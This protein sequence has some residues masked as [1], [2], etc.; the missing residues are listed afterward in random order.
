MQQLPVLRRKLVL[1][2]HL[3]NTMTHT[4]AHVYTTGW[5]FHLSKTG[6]PNY[7]NNGLI[8]MRVHLCLKLIVHL[9]FFLRKKISERRKIDGFTNDW[10]CARMWMRQKHTVKTDDIWTFLP[11]WNK[12][13]CR[14][15][16][17]LDVKLKFRNCNQTEQKVCEPLRRELSLQVWVASER[18][19]RITYI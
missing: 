14:K 3:H 17:F 9:C 15:I 6:V 8:S 16:A 5:H 11:F 4:Y 1:Y 10:E 13:I 18:V 7:I 12:P 19:K 2:I